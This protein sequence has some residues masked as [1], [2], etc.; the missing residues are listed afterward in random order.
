MTQTQM[1]KLNQAWRDFVHER[2]DTAYFNKMSPDKQ[3]KDFI[4]FCISRG[5][6]N[7]FWGTKI[8]EEEKQMTHDD[9]ANYEPP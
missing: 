9:L 4:T 5:V 7:V 1:E 2:V 3:N 8:T 6:E